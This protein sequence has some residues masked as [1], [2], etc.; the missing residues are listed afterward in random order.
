MLFE[1]LDAAKDDV[2]MTVSLLEKKILD[3]KKKSELL[4]KERDNLEKTSK[5]EMDDMKRRFDEELKEKQLQIEE[6]QNKIL[7][8]QAQLEKVKKDLEEL[9]T[10]K[11]SAAIRNFGLSFAR[12]S[13]GT[14]FTK[15]DV[16]VLPSELLAQ[17]TEGA[18]KRRALN[19]TRHL[20][21]KNEEKDLQKDAQKETID[22]PKAEQSE[23]K[24]LP[25]STKLV[26]PP[27]C[28]PLKNSVLTTGMAEVQ[29]VTPSSEILSIGAIPK[30]VELK[31]TKPIFK[32]K[33]EVTNFFYL[34]KQLYYVREKTKGKTLY[35]FVC[36][37]KKSDKVIVSSDK[38]IDIF[39]SRDVVLCSYNNEIFQL[40]PLSMKLRSIGKVVGFDKFGES[41]DKI[42]VYVFTKKGEIYTV[43]D[44]LEKVAENLLVGKSPIVSQDIVYSVKN[45]G[46]SVQQFGSQ[47]QNKLDVVDVVDFTEIGGKLWVLSGEKQTIN[48][49]DKMCES[50]LIITLGF[51]P[52]GIKNIGKYAFIIGFE[53]CVMFDSDGKML[54]NGK[55]HI[56]TMK[57]F[58]VNSNKKGTICFVVLGTKEIT[59]YPTPYNTHDMQNNSD[60]TAV[61]AICGKDGADRICFVCHKPFHNKCYSETKNQEDPCLV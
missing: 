5:T 11:S 14:N 58:G 24:V 8:E 61:C 31:T 25:P 54:F 35:E 56:D 20:H 26:A 12:T 39:T 36:S 2:L 55:L 38:P 22:T 57:K 42:T 10:K 37:T 15:T 52:V 60:T 7:A 49:V 1:S 41:D 48:I 59:E 17:P 29:L 4:E 30:E 44:G 27:K 28:N 23:E 16:P 3:E 45:S 40:E 6:F 53:K 18:M 9:Q 46:L 33:T 43:G 13:M 47:E 50:A 21:K 34:S 51:K 19:R 32:E